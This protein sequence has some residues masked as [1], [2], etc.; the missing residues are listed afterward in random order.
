M[1]R[2]LPPSRS[3]TVGAE[4]PR[5]LPRGGE[6]AGGV[7]LGLEEVEPAEE[8]RLQLV[9]VGPPADVDAK[10]AAGWADEPGSV[11]AALG[12]E[13]GISETEGGADETPGDACGSRCPVRTGG[14]E[15]I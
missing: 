13:T 15:V 8:V 14:A 1:T 3:A 6:R 2:W 5:S 12:D 4:L 7:T 11:V 9:P 10:G